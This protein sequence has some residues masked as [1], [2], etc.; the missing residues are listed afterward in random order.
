ML[1][2]IILATVP[3]TIAGI[4][5]V[6]VY[7]R[8]LRESIIHL[9]E[10]K[11]SRVAEKTRGFLERATDNLKLIARDEHLLK[12]GPSY[13][14]DH[15]SQFLS[16]IDYLME[17]SLLNEKG[18]EKVKVS[19]LK[20][21]KSIDPQDQSTSPMFQRASRGEIYYGNHY[22]TSDGKISMTIALPVEKYQGR[23]VSVM[24]AKIYLDPLTD[25]LRKTKIGEKGSTYVMDREEYLVAHPDEKNILLGPFVDRVIAGEEGSLEFENLRGEK[26]L[27]VY[28]PIHELKWGVIV[29][30]PVEEAYKPLGVITR[31]AI[32]WALIASALA[33]VFSF[34]LTRRLTSPIKRLSNEMAKVSAG[35]LD[36]H[37]EPSTKD[38]VGQLT[39]SFNRMIEDLKQSQEAIKEAERKYRNIFENS[40]EMAY[41]TSVD[42]QF[43]DVN[44]A[45][46]E[47][48]GYSRRDELMRVNI[49]EC[50]QN[51]EER[52]RFQKQVAEN[53][54]TKDFE[55]KLKKK[56]GTPL[57]CLITA[58]A[59]KDRKGDIIGYEGTI[60]DISDRKRME[61]ELLQ[62]TKELETLYD[63]S[64]LI[65]QSLDLD[66]VLQIAVEKAMSI[67]GFEIGAL[68]ILSEDEETLE[69]KHEK[70]NPAIL[71]EKIQR[72][73]KGE[74]ICG[75]VVKT[76]APLLIHIEGYPTPWVIPFLKDQGIQTLAGIP[77][78]SREK[79]IGSITLLSRFRRQLTPR[80]VHLLES[81]G[82]QI[83]IALENAKLFSS[84]EK[85]KSEWEA[86]FDTV[87]DLIT[88]R[89]RDYRIL[90]A[91]RTAFIRYGLRPEEMI[92]KKCYEILQNRDT[93]CEGCYINEA[94]KTRR[95]VSGERESTYLHGVF[96]Y[97]TYPIRD[98]S[99]NIVAVVDLA[100]EI[101]EE[102]KLEREKE[103]V[104]NIYKILASSL[105]VR[106]VLKAIHSELKRVMDSQRMTLILLDGDKE[107]FRYCALEKDY[108]DQELIEGMT[109]PLKDTFA[110]EVMKTG[111]PMIASNI[112]EIEEG[113]YWIREKLL[114][115]GI[116]SFLVFPL[117]YQGKVFGTMSLGSRMRSSFSERHLDILRQIAP[118]LAISLQNALL[119]DEIKGS[120]ERYRTVVEGA[121]DGICVIGSDNRIKFTNKGLA[122]IYGYS[123]TE[124]LETDF[125]NLL[126]E[127][128]RKFIADRFARREKGEK[129]SP[130]FE[131]TGVRKDGDV[132]SLEINARVMKGV[133]GKIDYIVFV[134]D[135][136]EKRKMEEQLLQ[137]EKLRALGE[138][139][140][141][142]A[143]DFNN[144]LA[145]ILGNAQLL[146]Y[147][148]QDEETREAL[149]TI[150]K[151]A[152]DSAQTV[153]RLQEFT[154]KRTRQE[155]FKVD[156]NSIIRDVI[157]ITKPKWKDEAQKKGLR[158][159]ITTRLDEVSGVEANASEMREVLTNI[160]LNAIE[161][162]PEGG[163]IEIRTFERNQKVH[164]QIADT[165]IG[166][167]EGVKKKIFEPFFTTKPFTNTGLGL[168]V[169]YGIVK[170]FGGEIQVQSKVGSGT[171]F[172]IVLPASGEKKEEVVSESALH[173]GRSARILIID[174]E[175]TIREVLAKMFSQFN[176]QVTVAESGEEGIRLFGEKR[177]DLVLTDLGMPGMSGW[178]VCKSIKE[179]EPS[180]PVG[181]ITGWGLEVDESRKAEAGLD[182]V[183]TKPFD[184]DQVMRMVSER[185]EPIAPTLS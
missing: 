91:N 120:E 16:R 27:V 139:A 174:D 53:G 62:R 119:L 88:V 51:P 149:K 133:K 185:I 111:N 156:I 68:H 173:G 89:D 129:L 76:K 39:L 2:S 146:L 49:Q 73:K 1:F 44:Q 9:Q 118:G 34:F 112:E 87:T 171:T 25:L 93:P 143:H 158:I 45:G 32:K 57:D 151:V 130:S 132:L 84:V 81:I 140:S 138:M 113:R 66:S 23:P 161:A 82:N 153:K 125:R 182:F 21:D 38:E 178:E 103:V 95:P 165:G 109:Y 160:L 58:T 100:R 83:G 40:K 162:M 69:L 104:N 90:R 155:L 137:N 5:I 123:L 108:E 64:T 142:V 55:V 10:E 127:E 147:T 20:T 96:Q 12:S 26:H 35:N 42:G 148:A 6:K 126:D 37:V 169:S 54:F 117:N 157:E 75:T 28:K 110:E 60:K 33:F 159:D 154:R 128:S 36:I 101:T 17:L 70:G 31:T 18:L 180:I 134:K 177:F 181:M 98:E 107:E 11:A 13:A 4:N 124:L 80:E 30:V 59:R 52:K 150:E 115:E 164:I 74:G 144:A 86:T 176:H 122:D 172:T 85:A 7:Q 175:E 15:L 136:T 94:L 79:A 179:M 50:Y 78:L 63:L 46:A 152:K 105:D 77:L 56:D 141:G 41:I 183:I 99:G 166:M 71:A 65:N 8:D 14:I 168:S 24:K 131:L 61:E 135:V 167:T 116:R 121:H 72:F 114:K 102:K 92:G 48:L 29:Q 3:L 19:K 163:R 145:A 106:Q 97:Y 22:Y 67:T 47:M 184:F 170:R 43:I